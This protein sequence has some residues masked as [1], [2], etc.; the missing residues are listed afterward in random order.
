M[1][2]TSHQGIFIQSLPPKKGKCAL[3]RYDE[4]DNLSA[5]AVY[6]HIRGI[7]ELAPVLYA[8]EFLFEK[9]GK[10]TKLHTITDNSILQLFDFIA[11]VLHPFA[12]KQ[13]DKPLVADR[14][15]LG[16]NRNFCQKVYSQIVGYFTDMTVTENIDALFAVGADKIAV[17][18]DN[19]DNRHVHQ[20]RHFDCL[21]HNHG[22]K[23]LRGGD[24]NNSVHR[25]ALE[26]RQRHIPV[27][28]GMS[29]NI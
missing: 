27:P 19:S 11:C 29:T 17:I 24:N 12:L 4:I 23:L 22:Y 15:K 14:G 8:D 20:L 16:V 9:L 1:R 18:F 7:P 10:T 2:S 13:L 21:C 5:A 28:G 25:Q 26:Y 3:C 6:L